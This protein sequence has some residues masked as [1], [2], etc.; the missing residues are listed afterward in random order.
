[1]LFKRMVGGN[2]CVSSTEAA[3]V[4]NNDKW[5]RSIWLVVH[6]NCYSTPLTRE[7][8]DS[9]LTK[10]IDTTSERTHKTQGFGEESLKKMCKCT[11]V[12]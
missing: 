7:Y 5:H 11:C 8:S 10:Y 6:G 1:M 2:H 3:Y 12:R 9:K 4:N